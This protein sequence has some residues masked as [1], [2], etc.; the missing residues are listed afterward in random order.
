[1]VASISEMVD[2]RVDYRNDDTVAISTRSGVSL[3]DVKRS[4]FEFQQ[5]GSLTPTTEASMDDT[6]NGVGTLTL[7][8]PNGTRINLVKQGAL[9][10]GTIAALVDMR[11]NT[12]QEAQRQLDDIASALAL[13]FST[14]QT[15]S[16]ALSSTPVPPLPAT[17]PVGADNGMMLDFNLADVQRGNDL[18]LSYTD[19][20]GAAKAVKIVNVT[21]P[22]V[23]PKSYVDA[24]GVS[25]YEMDVSAGPTALSSAL[26]SL[27]PQINGALSFDGATGDL[28][29]SSNSPDV[30][31][32]GLTARWTSQNA[33]G[34]SGQLGLQL[35]VD[36]GD[37]A[38]T[39]S[40]D[41]REQKLGFAGRITINSAVLNDNRL[42][43]NYDPAA[44]SGDSKRADHIVDQFKTM[45]FSSES[46]ANTE[47]GNFR[48]SGTLTDMVNQTI[49][50]QGSSIAS[51]LSKADTQIQSLETI[52]Q[53]M[54]E[55]YGVDVNEEVSRL[56]ELQNAYAANARVISVVQELLDALM[57]AV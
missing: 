48:L 27:S 49:E 41:G 5:A 40:L 8:T 50:Y 39:N 43:A 37:A 4:I 20:S 44:G 32:N 36:S 55:K 13:A 15:K 22:S 14:N 9:K 28:R 19:A 52:N 2:V 57:Q 33:Q 26:N 42:L 47:L 17:L 53:R 30:K 6:L 10:S 51:A 12:L 7:V 34:G 16:T 1:L 18:V 3:L 54:G 38:Y 35:F 23:P 31:V 25:V 21:T 46:R 29:V 56:M 45:K 24:Q 11:D